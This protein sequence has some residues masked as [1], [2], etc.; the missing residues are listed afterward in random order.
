MTWFR[1]PAGGN[2]RCP[3]ADTTEAGGVVKPA[4]SEMGFCAAAS[5]L[6]SARPAG[7]LPA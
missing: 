3:A 1:L 2:V 6:S 5:A 4:T 7:N